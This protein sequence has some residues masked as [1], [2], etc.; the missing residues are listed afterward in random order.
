MVRMKDETRSQATAD[1][2]RGRPAGSKGGKTM[3]AKVSLCLQQKLRICHLAGTRL[4]SQVAVLTSACLH[5]AA[6]AP[7]S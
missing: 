6:V 1:R 7:P 3:I 5:R 2:Y 4:K